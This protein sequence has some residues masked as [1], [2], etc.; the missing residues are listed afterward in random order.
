M[1]LTVC[2][3]TVWKLRNFVSRFFWKNSV[4]TTSLVKSFTIKLISRN[5]SQVIQNF[6]KLHTVCCELRKQNSFKSSNFFTLFENFVKLFYF[7]KS[8][9]TIP[10]GYLT[11]KCS[12]IF[13][14]VRPKSKLNGMTLNPFTKSIFVRFVPT[15]NSTK[16]LSDHIWRLFTRLPQ[17]FKTKIEM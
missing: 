1:K 6:C 17:K 2:T 5:N 11:K 10:F 8:Q 13:E 4:K 14:L 12:E 16:K 15:T 7:Q 9:F 3:A